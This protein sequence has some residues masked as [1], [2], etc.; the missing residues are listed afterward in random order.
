VADPD[1]PILPGSLCP[2]CGPSLAAKDIYQRVAYRHA[3]TCPSYDSI[4]DEEF[5]PGVAL[6]VVVLG[7]AFALLPVLVMISG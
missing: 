2:D 3:R 6:A 4:R 1:T 5:G 7:I